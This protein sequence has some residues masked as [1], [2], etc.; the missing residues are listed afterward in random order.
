MSN[1]QLQIVTGAVVAVQLG[2]VAWVVITRRGIWPALIVNLVFAAGVLWSVVPYVASEVS[3]AWSDRDSDLF[4]YK[5][6]ILT[7][8]ET[9]TVL[10]SLLAFRELLAAKI[11][12]WL[13][14]AGNFAL[15]VIAAVFAL[16][17]D[18]KCCG[19]L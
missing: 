18:F 7:G 2:V 5:N 16:T 12:A 4:D 6:S 13:G 9:V 19:Y 10:A 17:F 1:L 8:F 11:V 3:F 15:S 14:F